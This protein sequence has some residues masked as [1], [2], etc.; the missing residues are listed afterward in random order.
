MTLAS[1]WKSTNCKFFFYSR[2]DYDF[3]PYAFVCGDHVVYA[4][5]VAQR[6]GIFK[7]LPSIMTKKI[8]PDVKIVQMSMFNNSK[9]E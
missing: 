6:K 4:N 9:F 8:N 1:T 5:K 3:C 7:G 2:K